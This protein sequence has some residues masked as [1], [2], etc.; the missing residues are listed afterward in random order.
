MS[1]PGGGLNKPTNREGSVD[2]VIFERPKKHFV[3]DRKPKIKY[4]SKSKTLKDIVYL[5][6]KNVKQDMII[7]KICVH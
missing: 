1:S 4:F 6:S 7:M 5:F 2:L 3:T